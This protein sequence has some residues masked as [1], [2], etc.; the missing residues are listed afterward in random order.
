M[1]AAA[2]AG[3]AHREPALPAGG[4]SAAV[5]SNRSPQDHEWTVNAIAPGLALG[6]DALQLPEL[7]VHR[8]RCDDD[9]Q[10]V[11]AN[12]ETATDCVKRTDVA[13][14]SLGAA[15]A[16]RTDPCPSCRRGCRYCALAGAFGPSWQHSALRL[17]LV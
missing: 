4:F 11:F 8:R 9:Q 3:V 17:P 7:R 6:I 12:A 10:A 16:G 15:V 1:I 13:L 2:V 14:I 5:V